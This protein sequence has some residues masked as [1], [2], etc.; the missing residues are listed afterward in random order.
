MLNGENGV[1]KP[2]QG[3]TVAAR[4]SDGFS[5][6]SVPKTG[7]IILQT[8]TPAKLTKF[9]LRVNEICSEDGTLIAKVFYSGQNGNYGTVSTTFYVIYTKSYLICAIILSFILG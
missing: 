6:I 8:N 3:A 4:G 1:F 9:T 5:R 7:V 2:I